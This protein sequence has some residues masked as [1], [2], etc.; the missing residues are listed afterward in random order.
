MNMRNAGRRIA[1]ATVGVGALLIAAGSTA[2]AAPSASPEH[3]TNFAGYDALITTPVSAVTGTLTVP[4]ITCPATGVTDVSSG[5][6]LNGPGSIQAEVF[7]LCYDGA[8]EEQ[9]NLEV[10]ISGTSGPTE[11]GLGTIAV[12]PG[13][14]LSFSLSEKL[15]TQTLT[16]VVKDKTNGFSASAKGPG[17]IEPVAG[18]PLSVQAGTFVDGD[19]TGSTTVPSFTPGFT[20][21]ALKFGSSTLSAFS[22]TEYEMYNGTTLQIAT[23]K[24]STGGSFTTTFKH[25]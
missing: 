22:P 3:S 6:S 5:V 2:M 4:T 10:A 17:S 19:G 13:D 12:S 8:L 16:G 18:T 25:T 9:P 15:A 21:G 14:K 7:Y 11:G 23:G 1:L 20:I 24:I